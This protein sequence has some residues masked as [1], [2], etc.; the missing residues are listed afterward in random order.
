MTFSLRLDALLAG[1]P[2]LLADGKTPS[3]MGKIPIAGSAEVGREGLVADGQADRSVHGGPDKA[4]LHYAFDHYAAWRSEGLGDPARLAA[5]GAFGENLST[6][7]VTEADI[8]VGDVVRIGA[9]L[10]QVSQGRQP[11]FKLNVFH[12][13]TDM[14]YAVQKTRRTGWYYRVLETGTIAVGDT[15]RLVDR[16]QPDWPLARAQGVIW[17]R[18]FDRS[19]IE[20][21][22]ALPEL[23]D[24]WKKTL[25]KRIESGT[26]ESWTKRLTGV[27]DGG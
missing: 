23:A 10:L 25:A 19:E 15:V 1:Q 11:C 3:A 6:T 12:G 8:H 14:S 22:I 16:P 7:G 9:V 20:T 2:A 27:A 17:N 5:P 26:V 24:A 21:L 13:R 4:L 18:S